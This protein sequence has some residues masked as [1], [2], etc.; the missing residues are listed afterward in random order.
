MI[1]LKSNLS[2]CLDLSSL[3]SSLLAARSACV[4]SVADT[5]AFSPLRSAL[6]P[7]QH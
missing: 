3:C 4:C 6:V 7:R 2:C 1:L 5:D